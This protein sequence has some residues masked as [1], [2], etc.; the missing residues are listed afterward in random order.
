MAFFQSFALAYQLVSNTDVAKQVLQQ[1]II[2]RLLCMKNPSICSRL[3]LQRLPAKD[4][5]H[6]RQRLCVE[7]RCCP[8]SCR[9][10]RFLQRSLQRR[11]LQTK[12]LSTIPLENLPKLKTKCS[13]PCR[14]VPG[15]QSDQYPM[16]LGQLRRFPNAGRPA[17]YDCL[18]HYRS[19]RNIITVRS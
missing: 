3:F 11:S 10:P 16:K 12:S 14:I 1:L 8:R 6:P 13:P 15:R 7:S 18:R 5:H 9:H 4:R 19:C 2:N 17:K